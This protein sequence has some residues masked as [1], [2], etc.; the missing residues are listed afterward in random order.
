[1]TERRAD[2]ATRDVMAWLKCE[3]M[4]AEIGST[5]NGVVTGV[6]SFGLFVELKDIYTEGLVHI[7]SLPKDYYH[8]EAAKQRLVGERYRKVF[9]LGDEVCVQVVQVNLDERKVDFEL[10]S[11]L[12]S[13]KK[14][15]VRKRAEARAEERGEC[16]K[17]GAFRRFRY[18]AK[19]IC[20]S[21]AQ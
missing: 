11:K 5:F 16:R 10:V 3:Y 9:R 18:V 1:M 13:A 17:R 12:A 2:D 14:A 20:S 8:F 15:K 4:Q 21:V 6:T 19:A 7:T